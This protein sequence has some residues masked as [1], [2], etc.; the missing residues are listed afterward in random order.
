MVRTT[1]GFEISEADLKLRG[2]GSIDGTMQ[3]GLAMFK[4]TDIIRD[5][6]MIRV[7]KEM[8]IRIFEKDPQLHL[9]IHKKMRHHLDHYFHLVKGWSRIS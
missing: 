7:C 4:M 8:A 5:G 6:E 2:P 1:D 9:D 3:S